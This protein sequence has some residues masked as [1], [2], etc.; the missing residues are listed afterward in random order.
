MGGGED[1][2]EGEW[3]RWRMED[4]NGGRKED[5]EDG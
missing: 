5:V 3:K 2:E 1:R 4:R